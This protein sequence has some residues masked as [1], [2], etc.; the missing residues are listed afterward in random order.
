M[1]PSDRTGM[2]SYCRSIVTMALSLV[3]S[4]IFDVEKC[5]DL[6]IGVKGHSR[7]LKVVPFGTPC[8]VSY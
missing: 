2:T 7:S 6:D 5:H 4:E 1:S 8:M 3:V